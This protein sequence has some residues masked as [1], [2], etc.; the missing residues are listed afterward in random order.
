MGEP[1]IEG[2]GALMKI[3]SARPSKSFS[4]RKSCIFMM[5]PLTAVP[6]KQS[7][8]I[9][10]ALGGGGGKDGSSAG[11]ANGSQ[12]PIERAGLTARPLVPTCGSSSSKNT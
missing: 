3:S 10:R 6:C 12:S 7:T 9:L 5:R 8:R 2:V 1:S 4:T 11:S